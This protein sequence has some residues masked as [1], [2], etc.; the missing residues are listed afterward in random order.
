[1]NKFHMRSTLYFLYLMPFKRTSVCISPVRFTVA[2]ITKVRGGN[3]YIGVQ[4][5]I[6]FSYSRP[7][8]GLS[9][10]VRI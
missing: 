5:H 2:D 8:L 10:K 3:N 4:L 1:M 9:P 6:P 7:C